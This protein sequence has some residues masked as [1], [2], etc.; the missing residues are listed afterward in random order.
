MQQP[1]EHP[2][3]EFRLLEYPM[4]RGKDRG[5]PNWPKIE[6]CFVLSGLGLDLGV[7]K[8]NLPA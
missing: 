6:R 7:H 5:K 1:S 3:I 2:E 8:G 4:Q